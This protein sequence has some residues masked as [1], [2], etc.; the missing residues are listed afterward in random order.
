[1]KKQLM[2]VGIILLVGCICGCTTTHDI[3][4]D[5]NSVIDILGLEAE[6]HNL[7]ND[8]RQSYGLAPLEYDTMLAQIARAHSVN[9]AARNYF[10]HTNLEGLG[11]TERAKATGYNCYKNFG[12][13][14]TDGISENIF[15]NSLYS[16]V[17]YYSGVPVYVWNSQSMIASSTVAGW[18]NSSGHKENILKSTYDK[19][20]IGVALSSDYAVY[21]TQ[22]FW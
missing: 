16:S 19:E 4:V 8:E 3:N 12:S 21:I 20:G 22:D 2:I 14:F 10:N 17:S 15:K 9:M 7:I 18:M 1:M 5:E 6:I 11:P 13:Y